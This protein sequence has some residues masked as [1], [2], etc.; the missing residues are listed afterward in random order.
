M[1][2]GLV[3]RAELSR[4][5]TKRGLRWNT[6]LRL[7]KSRSCATCEKCEQLL[8]QFRSGAKVNGWRNIRH[9]EMYRLVPKGG[10]REDFQEV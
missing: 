9:G 7:L 2:K 8:D 5:Q 3:F 1:C 6:H 4:Q 10:S